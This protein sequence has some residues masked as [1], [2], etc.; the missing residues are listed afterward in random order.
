MVILRF[1]FN[2]VRVRVIKREGRS[3][4]KTIMLRLMLTNSTPFKEWNQLAVYHKVNF[5]PSESNVEQWPALFEK[6]IAKVDEKTY[7]QHQARAFSTTSRNIYK[8]LNH[9]LQ[10]EDKYFTN[11]LSAEAISYIFRARVEIL[12]LNCMP[13]RP[14]LP[15]TCGLCNRREAEDILHFIAVCPIL[16]EIRRLHFDESFISPIRLRE[17]LN[18]ALGWS[19]LYNYCKHAMNFRNSFF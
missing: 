16:Q 13:H 18:G 2:E 17:I 14:D 3:L 15:Q 5:F 6:I 10:S 4:H 8:N 9:H 11:D 7:I 12:N 1:I 19:S